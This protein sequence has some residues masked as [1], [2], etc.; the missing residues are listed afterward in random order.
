MCERLTRVAG[1]QA[2]ILVVAFPRLCFRN[3]AAS[4][5]G[6]AVERVR[7]WRGSELFRKRVPLGNTGHYIPLLGFP[8]ISR[9]KTEKSYC[10]RTC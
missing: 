2:G 7:G 1:W 4:G 8:F 5:D 10:E 6:V 9:F 3:P